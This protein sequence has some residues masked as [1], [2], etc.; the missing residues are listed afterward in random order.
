MSDTTPT[1]TANTTS[2]AGGEPT[3]TAVYPDGSTAP[4]GEDGV[5]ILE[6]RS[7]DFPDESAEAIEVV[8]QRVPRRLVSS[9]G[10]NGPVGLLAKRAAKRAARTERE[11][12][13]ET[14]PNVA[15]EGYD[16][17]EHTVAEVQGYLS[18][19]PEQAQYVLDRERTGKAR[20][21]LIGA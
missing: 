2:D 6:D 11:G 21:T 18:D 13:I 10:I 15:D 9:G 20:T 12:V 16:P 19:S 8:A 7:A 17:A 14:A 5:P 1:L 3:A 4:L